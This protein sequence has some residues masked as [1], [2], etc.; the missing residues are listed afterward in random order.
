MLGVDTLY[1]GICGD[2]NG[3]ATRGFWVLH[4][5]SCVVVNSNSLFYFHPQ[6]CGMFQWHGSSSG[7]QR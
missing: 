4:P 7:L 3:T 6:R 1:I 5:C 2:F